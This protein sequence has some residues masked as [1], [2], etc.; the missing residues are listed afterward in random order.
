VIFRTPAFAQRASQERLKL[1]G[2]IGVPH[3]VVKI[4]LPLP[5]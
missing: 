1:R 5:G 3:F 4:S 2:S